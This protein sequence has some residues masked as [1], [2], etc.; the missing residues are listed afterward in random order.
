M[1]CT[2]RPCDSFA[3]TV[4]NRRDRLWSAWSWDIL[5]LGSQ[6]MRRNPVF[7]LGIRLASSDNFVGVYI[8]EEHFFTKMPTREMYY[9]CLLGK[10]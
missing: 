4:N 9:S 1:Q 10:T 5:C 2:A 6:K 7:G 3:G 8:F